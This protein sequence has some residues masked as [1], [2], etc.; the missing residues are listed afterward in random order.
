[1]RRPIILAAF[2][3]GGSAG[4]LGIFIIGLRMP[5]MAVFSAHA[6]MA[7]AVFGVLLGLSPSLS[8]FTGAL[9]GAMILGTFLRHRNIDPNAALGILFS[10]K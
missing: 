8:G 2:L 1:M 10:P 4:L 9:I 5:F 3:G 7:G 6:A